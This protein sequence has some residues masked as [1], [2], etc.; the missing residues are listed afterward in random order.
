M[1][2]SSFN[3]PFNC[4]LLIVT[5]VDQKGKL[6]LCGLQV[7]VQFGTMFI[8]NLFNRFEL[9][10]YQSITIEIGLLGLLKRPAFQRRL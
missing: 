10:N 4:T 5:K 7:I 9:N 1:P 8:T 6:Q 3:N 2:P